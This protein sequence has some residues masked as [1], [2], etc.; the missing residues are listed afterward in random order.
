[1]KVGTVLR[2]KESINFK[3]TAVVSLILLSVYVV[4]SY[5]RPWSP[6]KGLGLIFGFLATFLFIYEMS[7]PWRRRLAAP[8]FSTAKVWLQAHIY[9]GVVAFVAV[10]TE[11]E[12]LP[13]GR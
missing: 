11:I 6:K 7:Y 1:M 3:I 13:V 10:V 8:P 4:A 9:L 5:L 12:V 2:P